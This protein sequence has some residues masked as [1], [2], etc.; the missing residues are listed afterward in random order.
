[1]IQFFPP[2]VNYEY[3]NCYFHFFLDSNG[4][5]DKIRRSYLSKYKALC[6]SFVFDK[7]DFVNANLLLNATTK[8]FNLIW[9]LAMT[10]LS[11]QTSRADQ[12][13]QQQAGKVGESR[14]WCIKWNWFWYWN[15]KEKWFEWIQILLIGKKKVNKVKI[16]GQIWQK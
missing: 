3:K 9:K 7:K 16:S 11:C 15:K 12:K 8:L 13:V 10:K 2:R 6:H 5:L 4:A 1:M 14:F